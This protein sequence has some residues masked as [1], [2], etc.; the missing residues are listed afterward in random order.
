MSTSNKHQPSIALLQTCQTCFNA[1]IRCEK[2]QDSELCDR[3]LRLGKACVFG[4]AR[5]RRNLNRPADG[6]RVK[7]RPRQTSKSPTGSQSSSSALNP[8]RSIEIFNKDAS[9]DP[10]QLGIVSLETGEKLIGYF[11]TR[12]TPYFPFVVFPDALSALDMNSERPCACLAALTVSSHADTHTQKALGTLFN[13]V[14]AAR[15]A[16]GKFNSLDLLQGLLIYLAWAHYS[17]RPKRHTQHLLLATSIVSDLRLDRPRRPELWSVDGGKDKNEPDWGHDEMRALAGVYYLSSNS[18]VV[19]QKS[20]HFS[21]TAYISRCCDH[22][23][24][25]D[26]HPTDKYLSYIIRIQTMA[27]EVEDIV[28]RT[29]TSGDVP[30]FFSQIQ[31]VAQKCADLKNTL[32]FSL[33]VSPPL[34]LQF[35]MLELLLS[36]ASPGGT[37]FG[38][39]KFRVNLDQA[40][41]QASLIDWLSTSI[42]AA[43]SLM[44][45]IL[46]LPQG[47]EAAMSNM[48]WIMMHCALSLAVRLDLLAAAGSIS[49]ATQ[50]LRK[51]LDMP[52]TLRQI[53]LRLEASAGSEKTHM[54]SDHHP[55]EDLAKR[56]R[57][58]EEWYLARAGR[59]AVSSAPTKSTQVTDQS[60]MATGIDRNT[61]TVTV[62]GPSSW[63]EGD[64]YRDLEADIGTFM[65]TDFMNFAGGFGL[66]N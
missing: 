27:E 40:G 61:A 49:G 58:L 41:G 7:S 64:W 34:L 60:T 48:G 32:P 28:S 53:M 55:F 66:G 51:F 25:L 11:K 56:G 50:H 47:E 42:S 22:L 54:A 8:G 30:Q 19:I 46:V 10:F 52:Y 37:P 5:R 21:Y 18:S 15:L 4:P 62:T 24:I 16:S 35:Y 23:A 6:L 2:T 20:R 3:C 12:M 1:K 63:V 45:M 36:Q 14:V 33:G 59:E 39:D 43:R 17:P 38:L 9:V 26:Q 65:F 31:L 57:K 29:S 13:Q 44:S